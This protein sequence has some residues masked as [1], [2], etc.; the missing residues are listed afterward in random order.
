MQLEV[1]SLGHQGGRGAMGAGDRGHENSWT[2]RAIRATDEDQHRSPSMA[3][4]GVSLPWVARASSEAF[5]SL[6]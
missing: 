5:P 6:L 3:F 2:R 1:G 4:G